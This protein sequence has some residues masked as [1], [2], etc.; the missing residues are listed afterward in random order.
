M[1]QL[2]QS[3]LNRGVM[4]LRT[5]HLVATTVSAIMNPNNLKV[6]GF[7]CVD[8]VD[9]KQQLVLLHQDIRDVIPQGLVINDHDVLVEPSDLIRLKEI[10][11]IGF[12]LV[13][14]PVVTENGR[15]LG[16]IND[17]AVDSSS[18]FVQKIY[19]TQSLIKNL[20]GG[21]LSV[22]R[23]RITEITSR[24]IVIK[25]PLEGNRNRSIAPATA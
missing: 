4:S 8:S 1:L 6:E 5:G 15:K 2:S 14:M 25:D 16:K 13:G 9:R 7:Y 12:Q 22:D 18:L 17:Y 11:D 3:F 21:S 10:L 20:G 19:V 23:S 24:R